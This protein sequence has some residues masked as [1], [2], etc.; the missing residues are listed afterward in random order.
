MLEPT[1]FRLRNGCRALPA[2]QLRD[3]AQNLEMHV[4]DPAA[5]HP[6]RSPNRPPRVVILLWVERSGSV[7]PGRSAPRHRRSNRGKGKLCLRKAGAYSLSR[8]P[9]DEA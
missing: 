6:L 5:A 2:L 9:E 4:Q 3:A 8:E 7:F 1:G